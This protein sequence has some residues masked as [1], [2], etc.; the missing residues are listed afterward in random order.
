MHVKRYFSSFAGGLRETLASRSG[1]AGFVRQAA[2]ARSLF[3]NWNDLD[4][5]W[6]NMGWVREEY[7]DLFWEAKV[8][9]ERTLPGPITER[10]LSSVWILH[11]L[12]PT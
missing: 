7:E 1:Q 2:A 11:A 8:N 12:V 10:F 4:T 9:T 6:E 5:D 3:G